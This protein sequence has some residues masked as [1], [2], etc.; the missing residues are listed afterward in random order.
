VA[1]EVLSQLLGVSTRT[2]AERYKTEQK[3]KPQQADRAYRVAEVF[4]HAEMVFESE[5]AARAWLAKPQ[6]GLGE[7]IPLNLLETEAG[8]RQVEDL[9]GRIEYGVLT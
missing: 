2:L 6:P 4:A 5:K 3:L 1:N 8:T 9:L 7:Q